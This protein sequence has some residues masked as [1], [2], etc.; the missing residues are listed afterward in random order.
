MTYD[1]E[2]TCETG[3]SYVTKLFQTLEAATRYYECNYD[4]W[5]YA[6]L[7]KRT[8]SSDLRDVYEDI[9]TYEAH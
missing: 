2:V 5:D 7:R 9:L 4:Q 3:T 1:Y 8:L 6:C